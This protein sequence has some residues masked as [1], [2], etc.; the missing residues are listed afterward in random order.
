MIAA[1]L[2]IVIMLVPTY[3]AWTLGYDAGRWDGFAA[4]LA[5]GDAFWIRKLNRAVYKAGRSLPKE[6]GPGC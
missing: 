2:Q 5:L 1:I 6:G 4:G 3:V